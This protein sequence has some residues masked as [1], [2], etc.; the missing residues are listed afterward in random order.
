MSLLD[1]LIVVLVGISVVA[2]VAAGFARVGIGFLASVC[3]LLFGFWFYG[4]PAELIKTFVKTPMAA[5]LIGFLIVFAAFVLAGALVGKLLAKFFHWTGLSWLDRLLGGLFG[6][7]RGGLISVVFITAVMAFTPKPLPNWMVRS[8][9]L[10]YA[11]DAS[12]MLSSL[13]PAAIKGAFRQSMIEIRQAWVDE[14]DRAK[15]KL[16]LKL[17]PKPAPK[18][19]ETPKP[20]APKAEPKKQEPKNSPAPKATGK[21]KEKSRVGQSVDF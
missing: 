7:V 11:I 13:A 3:G 1:I 21:Q 6:L 20:V 5:N 19:E 4:F 9:V 8:K 2:G 17:E 15:E 18:A 16:E 12:N 14:L 10:P